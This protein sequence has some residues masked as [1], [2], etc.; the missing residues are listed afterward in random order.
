MIDI[1]FFKVTASVIPTLTVAVVFTGK[2][3]DT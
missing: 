1:E 2:L 3:M